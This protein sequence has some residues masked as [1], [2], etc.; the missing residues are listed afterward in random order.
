MVEEQSLEQKEGEQPSPSEEENLLDKIV[1]KEEEAA[2]FSSDLVYDLQE[3]LTEEQRQNIYQ[4]I[5]RMNV[6]DKIRLAMLGN[7]EA[8][9][10]LI[11]DRNKIVSLAVIRSPKISENDVLTYAHQR[12]LPE[13]IY[14]YIARNKA[15]AKNYAI[16]MALA[17]NPK[18]PLPVAIKLLDHLH[19]KDLK[20]L[21]RNKNISSVLSK[22]AARLI[23]KRSGK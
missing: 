8:R 5:I 21:S 9:N 13:E 4:K 11:M 3:N 12:N 16:K 15:W 20:D 22:S 2:Q 6:P 14:K 19:D 10:I 18:T 17:N 7:R 1:V 23:I